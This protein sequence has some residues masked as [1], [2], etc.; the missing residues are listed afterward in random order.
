MQ[1]VN[2]QYFKFPSSFVGK[3]GAYQAIKYLT[4]GH[5]NLMLPKE[6]HME[7]IETKVQQIKTLFRQEHNIKEEETLVFIGAG[8][9]K[10]EIQYSVN[11]A[12]ESV[13]ELSKR[14][15]LNN[16]PMTNFRSVIS[17]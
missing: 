11:L 8:N 15:V 16:Q 1:P 14:P 10:Q 2:W 7:V 3:E 6:Y 5:N 12:L 13:I 9:T 17:V 4:G